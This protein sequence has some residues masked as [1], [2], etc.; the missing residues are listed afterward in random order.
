MAPR[1]AIAASSLH[2]HRPPAALVHQTASSPANRGGFTPAPTLAIAGMSFLY[3]MHFAKGQ[4]DMSRFAATLVIV[5]FPLSVLLG[6]WLGH[7]AHR[8][9]AG[10]S[11]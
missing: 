5:V 9:L 1:G 7:Q 6:G 2:I 4:D 11:S 8:K 3:E 10:R